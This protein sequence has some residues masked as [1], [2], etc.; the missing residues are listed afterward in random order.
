MARDAQIL[1]PLVV[2]EDDDDVGWLD[3]GGHPPLFQGRAE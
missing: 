1:R 2:G 3:C